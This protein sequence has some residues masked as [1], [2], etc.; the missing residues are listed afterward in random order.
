M[1]QFW[2]LVFS[3]L[4]F[5]LHRQVERGSMRFEYGEKLIKQSSKVL[6]ENV[7]VRKINMSGGDN[8]ERTA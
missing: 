5:H 6:N 3:P 1:I 8:E 4:T 7:I 2:D